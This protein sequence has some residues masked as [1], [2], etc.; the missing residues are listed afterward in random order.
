MLVDSY[1]PFYNHI[2][3][4]LLDPPRSPP[5]SS[6]RSS[7]VKLEKSVV[8]VETLTTCV[9]VCV[10]EDA[11]DPNNAHKEIKSKRKWLP[12]RE[13]TSQ[14]FFLPP[15]Q[16]ARTFCRLSVAAVLV[17]SPSPFLIK[18]IFA[19]THTQREREQEA[20]EGTNSYI[21]IPVSLLLHTSLDL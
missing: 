9:C 11:K 12:P 4:G 2:R 16:R 21:N 8:V 13:T 1:V 10:S 5:R 18:R 7:P 3:L 6:T 14:Y 19:D 20:G 17:P 15:Q